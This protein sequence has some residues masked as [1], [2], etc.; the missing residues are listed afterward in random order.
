MSSNL[1]LYFCA[2]CQDQVLICR[3]CDRGQVYCAGECAA[4]ARKASLRSAGARYA[5]SRPGRLA[6]AARQRCFRARQQQKV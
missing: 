5:A 6:N 1:R 4:Q 3:R 2:R